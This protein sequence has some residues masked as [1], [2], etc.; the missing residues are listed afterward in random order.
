M[1]DNSKKKYESIVIIV[2]LKKQ[3]IVNKNTI[4]KFNNDTIRKYHTT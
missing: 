1:K 2:T 3:I 4:Y